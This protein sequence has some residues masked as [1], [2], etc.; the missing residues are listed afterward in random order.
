MPRFVIL[1][2]DHPVLHWDLML[3]AGDALKTWRLAAPPTA[4]HT[5]AA[6]YLAEHRREYLDYEGPVSRGR[7]SLKRWDRGVYAALEQSHGRLACKL[8]G[9]RVRGT[10]ELRQVE[11]DKWTFTLSADAVGPPHPPD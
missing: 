9:D 11:A 10:I 1:E 4:G 5:I 8:E 3:E 6:V 2:H 7:G